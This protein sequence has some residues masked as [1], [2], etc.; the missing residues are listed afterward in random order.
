M[1]LGQG[2]TV[3]RPLAP[4]GQGLEGAGQVVGRRGGAGEVENGVDRASDVEGDAHVGEDQLE[5]GMSLEPGHVVG[6]PGR[7]V[8]DA[9]HSIAPGHQRVTEMRAEE[10]RSPGDDHTPAHGTH[11]LTAPI[12]SRH[13]PAHGRPT[14][15]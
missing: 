2:Q 12:G 14:P 10:S 5:P 9:D 11:L 6:A 1:V 4:H 8:V 3:A 7:Q 15:T 13:P